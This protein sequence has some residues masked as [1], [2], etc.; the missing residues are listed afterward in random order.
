MPV[1]MS[2]LS[3]ESP[4]TNFDTMTS[5]PG[6]N[7]ALHGGPRSPSDPTALTRRDSYW[8][9]KPEVEKA[10]YVR[11]DKSSLR[12][13]MV[14]VGEADIG[15]NIAIQDATNPKTRLSYL[16]AKRRACASPLRGP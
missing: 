13:A 14:Q 3:I 12:A 2:F 5:S 7:G 10:T 1:F 16:T 11:R 4:K 8:G 9:E 6:G 15:L